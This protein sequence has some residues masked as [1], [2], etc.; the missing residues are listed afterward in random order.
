MRLRHIE[1]FHAVYTARSVTRAAEILNCSQPSVSK[2]LSHAEQQLGYSLF[3][4][5]RGKLV[6]T[7]EAERLFIQVNEVNT[8][9][10][11]LRQVAINLREAEEG[12][13][14]IAA[15]PALGIELL[16]A[17]IAEYRAVHRDVFFAVETRHHDGVCRALTD[18]GVDIGLAFSA[19]ARAGIAA[20]S[21]GTGSFCI[22][23]PADTDFG[24]RRYLTMQ[25]IEG[26]PYVSLDRRGPLGRLVSAHIE[27][28]GVQ[29]Q[30]IA[31]SET[32]HLGKSL[33][34]QGAGV[35][36]ADQVTAFSGG[37]EGLRVWPLEPELRFEITVLHLEN[38]PMSRICREFVSQLR[39]CVT[40]FLERT[41]L[42]KP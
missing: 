26:L 20:Q 13:I 6:P 7:P 36:I 1:V 4:R 34:A 10:D 17:A 35:M 21:L 37:C 42:A 39:E 25:D 40:R 24:T 9:L 16:P 8:S 12:R 11:R 15:T 28:S 5:V 33:V 23:A 41:A 29:L 19:D 31:F 14:R 3:E 18:S 30:P 22:L 32:Y 2:V 27:S 38:L